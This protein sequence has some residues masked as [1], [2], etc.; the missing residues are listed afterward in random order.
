MTRAIQGGAVT[1]PAA[2]L[3]AL[4]LAIWGCAGD[5]DSASEQADQRQTAD[6]LQAPNVILI[7]IDTL[8]PDHLGCYGYERDTSPFLD[9]LA[10]RGTL[11]R[12]AFTTASWTLPAHVSLLTGVYPHTH[13][14]ETQARALHPSTPTLAG[15][16]R[17]A[18]YRTAGFV[19]WLYV[20]ST[21]GLNQGFDIYEEFLPPDSLIDATTRHSIPA[22]AFVDR[23]ITRLPEVQPA[24]FFLFLHL[25]DPHMNYEPPLAYAQRFDPRIRD[26]SDLAAGT[27]QNLRPYISGVHVESERRAIPDAVRERAQV[28]YD[29]EVRFVDDQLR[30]LF[31]VLEEREILDRSIVIISSDHGE[32]FGEHGSMEGHQWTLYEEVLRMPLIVL[33]PPGLDSA[34]P[35]RTSDLLIDNVDIAPTL[36]ELCGLQV[37]EEM[38]GGSFATVW[39]ETHD[40]SSSAD[41]SRPAGAPEDTSAAV[42]AQINRFNQKWS[43]RT[44][45]HKLIFSRGVGRSPF[46]YEIPQRFEFYDLAADPSEQTDLL[47]GNPPESDLPPAYPAL[48]ERLRTFVSSRGPDLGNKIADLSSE[49]KERLRSVGYIN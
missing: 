1:R 30:R 9:S 28:L 38:E 31:G 34:R 29:G 23:V 47:A 19:S 35:P 21:F 7:S 24:P 8:R 16:F 44:R 42:F 12:E 26:A 39:E 43:I 27:Y 37:P 13:Q 15:T 2:C 40:V 49:E 3:L 4:L 5:Q 14:V 18:G 33:L 48:M 25:F 41:E 6:V 10:E 46:G 17:E 45:D 32:E 36:L 20:S 22:D 11:F